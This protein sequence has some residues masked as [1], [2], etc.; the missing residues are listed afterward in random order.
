MRFLRKKALALLVRNCYYILWDIEPIEK[1]PHDTKAIATF[2]SSGAKGEIERGTVYV[3][4][5]D[6]YKDIS[7]AKK[8]IIMK[9]FELDNG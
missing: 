4:P 2:I 6:V 5:S 1:R 9:W 7:D 8:K 3:S